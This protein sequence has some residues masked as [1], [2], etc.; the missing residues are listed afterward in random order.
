MGKVRVFEL[1]K[2]INMPSKDLVDLLNSLGVPTA[3][4]MSAIDD[5]A[6]KYVL[7]KYGPNAE[8]EKSAPQKQKPAK[9]PKAQPAPQPPAEPL[10]EINRATR[11]SAP[12]MQRTHQRPAPSAPRIQQPAAKPVPGLAPRAAALQQAAARLQQAQEEHRIQE[13]KLALE[14][15]E[16]AKRAKIEAEMQARKAKERQIEEAK[17]KADKEAEERL[18]AA[19][20]A[21]KD[22]AVEKP[23][24]DKSAQKKRRH[25]AEEA[26]EAEKPADSRIEAKAEETLSQSK[27][28]DDSEAKVGLA[29]K[30]AEKTAGEPSATTAAKAQEAV[31]QQAARPAAAASGPRPQGQ[32]LGTATYNRPQ[33]QGGYAP[34]PQGQG[35]G[36]ATYRQPGSSTYGP[37]PQGQGLGTAT[38]RQPGSSTYGPRPQGQGLGT[39]TYNRPQGQGGFAPRPQGQGGFA[40]RPQGTGT[41]FGPRRPSAPAAITVPPPSA[42]VPVNKG[43]GKSWGNTGKE[44]RFTS[45][46]DRDIRGP[47][48]GKPAIA[49]KGKKGMAPDPVLDKKIRNIDVELLD[50]DEGTRKSA[51]KR[52][53]TAKTRKIIIDAEMTVRDLALKMEVTPGELIKKLMSLGVMAGINQVIDSDTSQVV[54][55]E[56]GIETELKSEAEERETTLTKEEDKPES[57]KPRPPVVTIM[58]HVDHGKT[59]LLDAIRK[60]DVAGGEAGGITQAIGAYQVELKG[61]R[62]TFIDTPGHAAFTSMRARGAQVTD[63]VVLVVAADDGVMPQTI[64]AYNHAKSAGVPIIVAIN[65][66]DRPNAQP[67]RVLQELADMGLVAEKWGGDTVT[68]EV[69]ALKKIGINEL[70]EMILLVAD[71]KD[72]R[73]NYERRAEGIVIE[74]KIDKGKGPV[75]TVLI[76]NGTLKQGDYYLVGEVFGRVRAMMNDKGDIV[77]EAAP[78]TPVEVLGL[79][80]VP[81]AGDPF[82]VITDEREARVIAERRSERRRLSEIV[83]VKRVTL[84]DFFSQKA[85]GAVKDLNI[86]VKA[87]VQGSVEAVKGSLEKLSNNEVRVVTV[88][89]GVG[90]VTESDVMLASTSNSIIIAFNVRPDSAASKAAEE[91]RV[92]IRAYRIIYEAINDV[93]L[94]MEG[95]LEPEYKEVSLGKAEVRAVFSVPKAGNIAGSYVTEGKITRN[96]TARIIRDGAVIHEG[97]ITSLRRFKDDAREVLAGF[98]CGIGFESFNDIKESDVIEAYG[99]E[100]VKRTIQVEGQ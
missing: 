72:L 67:D 62:I 45:E 89:S 79:A 88:H 52:E 69:S 2:M 31:Q 74:A 41:G 55:S 26:V 8:K 25:A 32:G 35:L 17:E 66:I 83:E 33:G 47:I 77:S 68:V 48:K 12:Q 90:A 24:E 54:A 4:H 49:R 80:G 19:K 40:P 28:A 93:A 58:G 82:D 73:A 76:K 30:P 43:K 46:D 95:L 3:N 53:K 9:Q 86:I 91:S 13:A 42:E 57:L 21:D 61:R 92:D 36:T 20:A 37:R 38:Y 78:S 15:E 11:Q 100:Q 75:A 81:Q 87:D 50:E 23:S 39:A 99:K 16:A 56:F 65:K 59:S 5:N 51:R 27:A 29:Q 85:S 60:T 7:R 44:R 1:S 18:A 96:A 14:R 70:L 98:E 63:I 71:M 22:S 94:A 34:R 97:K 84:E 64:E 6:A 10:I